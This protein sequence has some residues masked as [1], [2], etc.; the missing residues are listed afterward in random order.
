[1]QCELEIQIENNTFVAEYSVDNDSFSH[2]FGVE[3]KPDYIRVDSVSLN[4]EELNEEKL[5]EFDLTFDKLSEIIESQLNEEK[6][7]HLSGRDS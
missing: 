5:R 3:A 2:L 1:M 7:F 4:G 6:N